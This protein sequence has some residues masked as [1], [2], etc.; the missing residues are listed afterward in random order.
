MV[1]ADIWQ[2]VQSHAQSQ[3]S[4][5]RRGGA[6]Q[7]RR[8]PQGPAALRSLRLRHVAHACDQEW[9]QS[10]IA[11][12]SATR[13]R[14][15]V[16]TT[17]LRKSIPATEIERFVVEQIKCIGKD[18]ALLHEVVAQARSQGKAHLAELETER[19]GLER[20]LGRW[21]AEVGNLLDQIAPGDGDTPATAR[22]ADLQEPDQRG[23]TPC[24]R[25]P[26][27]SC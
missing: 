23:G 4:H 3:R 11:T 27:A 26:R 19:R 16:G 1:N 21:N 25:S 7:L 17:A 12:T 14:N 13:P 6:E 2:R 9:Q 10:G 18:P 5:G 22:L 15:E 24:N 20:E 8:D